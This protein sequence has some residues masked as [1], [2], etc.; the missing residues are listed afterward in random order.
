MQSCSVGQIQLDPSTQQFYCR[1]LEILTESKVPFLVG[2]AYALARYTG[3]ER[4]TKDLD[5]FIRKQDCQRILD[6]FSD[7][8]YQ[9]ELTFPHWLGKAFCGG[10]FVDLIFGSGNG[11]APVDDEWFEHAVET[12]VL[13][14]PAKIC[15]AE[16][17]LW[18][19]SFIMERERFDGGGLSDL[20]FARGENLDWPRLLRRFD[21][22]WQVLLS[23]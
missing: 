23:H 19:K 22:R 16:E 15:P 5:I 13:G 17:I 3:I 21:R 2:G 1:S 18:S 11:I 20:V 9:T 12:H 6:I 10:D 14:V 7:A 4:H 8:G